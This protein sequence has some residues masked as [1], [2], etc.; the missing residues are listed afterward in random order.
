MLELLYIILYKFILDNLRTCNGHF[1][2]CN[3]FCNALIP[4]SPNS[5]SCKYNV[6][7]FV[8]FL[9]PNAFDNA[10]IPLSPIP[11]S[12]IDISCKLKALWDAKYLDNSTAP[13][14]PIGLAIE[15][16]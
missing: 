4:S 15:I 10:T 8:Q 6:F 7:N 14:E 5:F 2:L 11:Q 3:S 16:D 9:L 13:C 12:S 1:P